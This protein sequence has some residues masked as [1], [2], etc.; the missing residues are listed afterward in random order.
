MLAGFN[1]ANSTVTL[2]DPMKGII[3][4]NI[5]KF[6]IR[7]KQMYSQAIVIIPDSAEAVTETA[8]VVTETEEL[9]ETSDVSADISEEISS[10]T[11]SVTEETTE[12]EETV[13]IPSE[14]EPPA[15]ESDFFTGSFIY[16]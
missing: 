4:Y 3:D 7:F 16:D 14:T 11:T 5:D 2:N 8:A 15:D 13:T 10:E 9:P 12:T 6:E 1:I